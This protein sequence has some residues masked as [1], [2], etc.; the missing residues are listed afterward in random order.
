MSNEGLC[1]NRQ[2]HVPACPSNLKKRRLIWIVVASSVISVI[3][4]A[5]AIVFM[6]MRRRGKTVN[7]EDEWLP[8]VAPQRISYYELQRATQGF[9]GNTLLGSGSF[10]SVYKGTLADGMIV[11]VKV[12]NVQ[13]EGTFQ[14]FDR[15]CEILRNL[16]HRNLTKII[17]SCCNLDFKALIL[18][19]MPNESLDKLLYSRDY[20]LNIMQRLNIMVDVASALEYLHHGYSVPVIHCDLKPSNVLLDNDMVGHLSDF[21]IA[22][23]LTKEESI[24]HTTTFATIGYIAPEYGLEGLVSKTSDVYSYDIM[25][26]EVFTKKKPNDEMF[27][28]DLNLRSCVHNSLPDELHQI[29]DTDLL[30]LDEQNLSQ[31]LQCLTSIMELAMNCTANIPGER[32]NMTDVVAAL[33]KIKQQLSSYY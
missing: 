29:I 10:G 12:F 1:G 4:L 7:A 9:D 17:S 20:C 23:L 3:A 13:M 27:T 21:G 11:V 15:E 31:K 22:K 33:K 28:G 26:L 25:L 18:E 32:M 14:T 6:L 8:E 5:S 16:R 30:T 2:K 24:A 19:Y